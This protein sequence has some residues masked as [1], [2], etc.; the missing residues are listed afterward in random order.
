MREIYR[1]F[2]SLAT[3]SLFT[4]ARCQLGDLSMSYQEPQEWSYNLHDDDGSSSASEEERESD[5]TERQWAAAN[6]DTSSKAQE[7]SRISELASSTPLAT[8]LSSE[9]LQSFPSLGGA[10]ASSPSATKC[11]DQQPD[12]VLRRVKGTVE[13]SQRDKKRRKRNEGPTEEGGKLGDD[14]SGQAEIGEACSRP[15]EV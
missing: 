4:L 5:S 6:L 2:L 14:V 13:D 8:S 11:C 1:L 15:K 10:A 3:P 7:T 12:K 9:S